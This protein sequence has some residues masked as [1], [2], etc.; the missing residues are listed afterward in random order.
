MS[1]SKRIHSLR[2]ELLGLV[3]NAMLISYRAGEILKEVRDKELWK[4][5]YESFVSFY[6]DPELGYRKDNVSRAIKLVENFKLEEVANVPLWKTYA[7]LPYVNKENKKELLEKA[8]T[9]SLG[10]LRHE[11]SGGLD[12]KG[13]LKQVEMPK[14]YECKHCKG[15]RGISWDVLCHCG[16]TP[17]QIELVGKLI[18]KID[19]GGDI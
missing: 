7:I 18:D 3:Q 5:Q 6:S 14:I 16:W 9:L 11:L 17:R 2:N 1:R 8:E 10:D 13:K 15:M 4:G 12:S 19:F